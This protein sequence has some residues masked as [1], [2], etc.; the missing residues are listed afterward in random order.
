MS[1]DQIKAGHLSRKAFVYIRQSSN[2]QVAH[3]LESQSRQRALVDR[4]VEF[5][6]PRDRIVQ[7]DEDL[8]LSARFQKRPGFEN[9]V[10]EV[11]LERVGIILALEVSRL[12]RS[13][14]DWY[15]LLDICAVAGTLIADAD[16]LYDP[17]AYNDRLVLGLKATMSEAELHVLKQR[18]VESIRAKAR[19][20]EFR[21]RL[22]PGFIWDLAGCIVKNPDEQVRSTIELIFSRFD[23]LGTVHRTH[24]SLL[25]EGVRVPINRGNSRRLLE[26]V[27]PSYNY[28][29]RTLRNPVYAGAYAFG[30]T[31][32]EE[33]LDEN[34]R[35]RKRWRRK[36]P[37]DWHALI[38][39]HHEGY[40]CWES[41]LRNQKQIDTNQGW[42]RRRGAAREGRSLLQG[43]IHCGHCGRRMQ[44]SYS[45]R[46]RSIYY[47]CRGARMQNAESICQQF[48]ATLLEQK[49]EQ[50][51]LE[52]LEP[53]G[54]EAMIEAARAQAEARGDD[55]KLW[56]QRV[57]RAEY[58]AELA[59][60]QYDAVDA[61]NR[62]VARELERRYERALERLQQVQDEADR[63]LE[64][65]D[66]PLSRDEEQRLRRCA[67]DL[68]V[69]WGSEN[70]GPQDK[71]RL[72]RAL[73]ESVTVTD[74]KAKRTVFAEVYWVGGE[75]TAIELKRRRVGVTQQIADAELIDLI[76]KLA[77]ELSDTQIARMLNRR[78][79]RTP[80]G[81]TFTTNRVSSLRRSH[82]IA[83]GPS[84][85]HTGPD[86]YSPHEAAEMLGV[87]HTT[88]IRWVEAGLLKGVQ[89]AKSA[90]WRIQVTEEDSRRL[91]PAEAAEDW[92][93]LKAAAK[94]LGISQQAVLQR[95]K[96]GKLKG[97]RVRVG[98]RSG[99]RIHVPPT[100]Y[101]DQSALF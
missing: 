81:L 84:V 41:Y 26:W 97:V 40:I 65:L 72:V 83:K 89:V 21:L 76:R 91:K 90:P 71:K 93:S 6:W 82:G 32:V 100:G 31:Q 88:I 37:S 58:E 53:L 29:L 56:Q 16:G 55:K 74:D 63:R 87:T 85:P 52:A 79:I 10:S 96:S 13:N 7:V 57:E 47:C 60:R 9:M 19:R 39:D 20:G 69:L 2:H 24:T 28:L 64:E 43:L 61:T 15:H 48:C 3:N 68:H 94:T 73:I 36:A 42:K 12:S 77:R 66:R 70:A 30:R 38:P 1:R 67:N 98:R 35:P 33:F 62:L 86:I 14:Q 5:G 78:G 50:L 54:V 44:V 23:S 51:L 59:R 27:V 34:R 4:A 46:T 99:W 45:S 80:K 49:T 22:P 92:L 8:G 11:A 95:L 101:D 17:R 25:E 18:L 75:V